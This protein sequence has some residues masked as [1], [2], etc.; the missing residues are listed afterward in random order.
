MI[1]PL[2]KKE[3]GTLADLVTGTPGA[4]HRQAFVQS[5]MV[6]FEN[7]LKAVN[8]GGRQ[9]TDKLFTYLDQLTPAKYRALDAVAREKA[10]RWWG[11]RR[12]PPTRRCW[13]CRKP[14]GIW[15]ICW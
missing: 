7:E 3:R 9:A 14:P 13:H 12:R 11:F 15:E 10:G 5:H 1:R 4:R 6:D 2:G 8:A